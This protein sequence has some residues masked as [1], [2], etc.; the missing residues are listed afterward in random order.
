MMVIQNFYR[1][2]CGHNN[3][4]VTTACCKEYTCSSRVHFVSKIKPTQR[5]VRKLK[6]QVN[7]KMSF[8]VINTRYR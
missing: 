4:W 8:R 6:K 2:F 3:V 1:T 7:I 5:Q